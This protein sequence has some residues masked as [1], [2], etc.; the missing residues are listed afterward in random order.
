MFSICVRNGVRSCDLQE[1]AS[2]PGPLQTK[3][4][5]TRKF[6]NTSTPGP[7]AGGFSVDANQDRLWRPRRPAQMTYPRSSGTR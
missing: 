5:G 1:V 6:K 2:N 3:G 4:S 7:P